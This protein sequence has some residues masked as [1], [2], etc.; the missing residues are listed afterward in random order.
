MTRVQRGRRAAAALLAGLLAG[1]L[2][3][4]ASLVAVA[5]AVA[6]P[7]AAD[8]VLP[9]VQGATS[10]AQ[11]SVPYPGHSTAF[12]LT[13]I[14][15]PGTTSDLVLLVDGG[16]GPLAAGPDSLVLAL[17]DGAGRVLA[18]GT[19]AELAATPIAL[20][21]LGPEPLHLHGTATLP[22]TAGDALQGQGLTLL[23]SLVATQDVPVAPVVPAPEPPAAGGVLAVTGASVLALA[24][25]A[26]GLAVLGLLLAARRRRSPS[27]APATDLPE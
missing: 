14:P 19:A 23:L 27:D 24:A 13:A 2:A 1:L 6:A 8:P 25:L 4:L 7:T 15:R 18:E 12:D 21:V 16:T 22:A 10:T 3:L 5:P 9:L 17:S 11:V 26:L 20:G